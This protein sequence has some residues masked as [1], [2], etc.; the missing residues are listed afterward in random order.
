VVNNRGSKFF[1]I[2]VPGE[3]GK[4]HLLN[5]LL[6]HYCLRSQCAIAAASS[7]VASVIV[8]GGRAAH[9]CLKIPVADS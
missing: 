8:H 5:V 4:A 9:C 1:F 3:T 6:D 7:G 2:D